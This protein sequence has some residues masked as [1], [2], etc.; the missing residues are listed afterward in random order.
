MFVD[1]PTM[2]AVT[3]YTGETAAMT[4]NVAHAFNWEELALTTPHSVRPAVIVYP[5][6]RV[7]SKDDRRYIVQHN[8]TSNGARYGDNVTLRLEIHNVRCTDR[9]VFRCTLRSTL[10]ERPASEASA[11]LTVVSKLSCCY[12][13]TVILKH[14]FK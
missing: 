10:P 11:E 2:T 14:N 8:V 4:C 7:W 12:L 5:D 3:S 1:T 6:S 9:G 13:F